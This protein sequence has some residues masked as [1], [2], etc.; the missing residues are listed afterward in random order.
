MQKNERSRTSSL[1]DRSTALHSNPPPTPKMMTEA[2]SKPI[3]N[4]GAKV[5][6]NAQARDARVERD[7]IGDF[8]EFIRSTG[9]PGATYEDLQPRPVPVN[10]HRGQNGSVRNTSSSSPR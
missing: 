9:P 4:S 7:S 3:A 1:A 8:A 10:M 2:S 6:L 5:K